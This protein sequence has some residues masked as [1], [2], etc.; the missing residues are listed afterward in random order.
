MASLADLFASTTAPNANDLRMQAVAP[1]KEKRVNPY[2]EGN[3][4]GQVVGKIGDVLAAL[5]GNQPS[6]LKGIQAQ[7]AL[8]RQEKQAEL[9]GQIGADPA[10]AEA[11]RNYLAAGGDVQALQALTPKPQNEGTL[12]REILITRMLADPNTPEPIRTRLEQLTAPKPAAP[13]KPILRNVPGVG[14]V[15]ATDP[16]NP[17]VVM[18]Q[19]FAPPRTGSGGGKGNGKPAAGK[20]DPRRL[21]SVVANLEEAYNNLDAAGGAISSKRTVAGNIG[22]AVGSSALGQ[23]AGRALGS[24]AQTQR[25]IIAGQQSALLSAIAQ[26]S[27]VGAKQLDSNAELKFYL[28][29]ATDPT[30]SLEANRAALDFIKKNYLGGGA[31]AAPKPGKNKTIRF[32]DLP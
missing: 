19:Q 22:S 2:G 13:A 4:F 32:E 5:G 18:Q 21:A 8:A 28:K 7:E 6:Y 29:Q 31:S 25:D 1:V 15:D 11:R 30:Q 14:L 16:A 20:G 26:A 3:S 24:T 17:R 9:L 12:P 10:N 23:I 27:G